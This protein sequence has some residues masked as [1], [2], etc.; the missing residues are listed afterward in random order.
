[1]ALLIQRVSGDYHGQYFFPHIA[2]VGNSSNL[3]VW[4]PS[5]D[6]DAGMLRLVFG[7]G[8]RAVDRVV[9]DY[10]RIVCLDDPTRPPLISYG[11]EKK[12]SQHYID[13][14]DT[15]E[16][17]WTHKSVDEILREDIKT[18]KNLFATMD[19]ETM[20]WLRKMGRQAPLTYVVNL[21]KLLE[22][23]DFPQKMK[24]ILKR[25]S[26][27]YNYP[28]DIEFAANFDK[29]GNYKINLL[30]CRPL[31]T[32]GLGKTVEI[33]E[34][35][36]EKDCFFYSK[37][38]FMG[39]NVRIPIDYVIYIKAKDYLALNEAGRYGV[40]RVV[41]KLNA[42]MKDKNAMLIGPGRWG[43]TTTS[44][45]VPV[46]FTELCHMKAICEVAYLE[47]NLMPEL[48]SDAVSQRLVCK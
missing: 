5:I 29:E 34:I 46:H 37:G 8:T 13:L 33:H 40:A 47:G 18:D 32:R 4:D 42:L 35:S 2:G 38:N 39:G 28:V 10:S 9:G 15:K 24:E 45:G 22:K 14:L 17:E 43:T 36:D 44:L 16:N 11:D 12:F 25:I 6:M 21:K 23:T 30:Q 19:Y 20:R 3:Y 31:Q 7:L 26:E 41:G 1:M 27:V 48:Y